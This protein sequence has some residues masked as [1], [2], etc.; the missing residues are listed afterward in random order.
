MSVSVFLLQL[1]LVLLTHL[2]NFMWL[3]FVIVLISGVL[4]ALGL[5]RCIAE[6]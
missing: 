2:G 1:H 3:P 4:S 5:C 6:T